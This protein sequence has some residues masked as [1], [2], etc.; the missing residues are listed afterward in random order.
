[1]DFEKIDQNGHWSVEALL[2]A[3][4]KP[5]LWLG[6]AGSLPIKIY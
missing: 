6:K 4:A 2:A 3:E 5:F 1:V